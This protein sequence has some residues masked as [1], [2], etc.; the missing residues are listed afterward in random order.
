[1]SRYL[2]ATFETNTKEKDAV[3]ATN[4]SIKVKITSY[5]LVNL[6]NG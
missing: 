3:K 5:V 4:E 6:I 1:M 2:E